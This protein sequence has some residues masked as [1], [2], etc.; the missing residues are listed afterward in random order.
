V[1][2]KDRFGNGRK[3]FFVFAIGRSSKSREV[4]I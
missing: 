3:L 4:T 1:A 2:D